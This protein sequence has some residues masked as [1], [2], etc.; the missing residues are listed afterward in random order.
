MMN[1][2]L[3]GFMGCGKTT[4]GKKLASKLG[5][6]FIDLDLQIEEEQG[7]SIRQ[8]F[9]EFGEDYFRKLESETLK[10]IS[11]LESF[12]LSVGGGTPCHS[13]NIDFMKKT[14]L[15]IY[16]EM[17]PAQL[18]SRIR[19]NKSKRPLVKDL[20]D[21]ELLEFVRIKLEERRLFYEKAHW[22]V[23]GFKIDIAGLTA[24]IKEFRQ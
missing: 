2:Y 3:I 14:G 10:S 5:K 8:I 21:S 22:V 6:P 15:T 13:G 23:D 7:R 16:L 12:V 1:I 9:E 24:K 18:A 4:V 17:T 19:Q 11:K 20:N